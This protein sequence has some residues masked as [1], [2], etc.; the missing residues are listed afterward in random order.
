LTPTGGVT[1]PAAVKHSPFLVHV[2][3]AAVVVVVVVPA[4]GKY[5]YEAL[6]PGVTTIGAL[7]AGI[8]GMAVM[9]A[10]VIRFRRKG[11]RNGVILQWNMHIRGAAPVRPAILPYAFSGRQRF[12]RVR[13]TRLTTTSTYFHGTTRLAAMHACCQECETA[14]TRINRP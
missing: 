14:F 6:L 1:L 5:M 8:T 7:N 10:I 2:V 12:F 9:I 13:K 3:E 11:L 4:L